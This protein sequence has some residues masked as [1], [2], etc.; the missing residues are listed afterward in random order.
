MKI[1]DWTDCDKI[2]F[3]AIWDDSGVHIG[4]IVVS[5]R[6]TGCWCGMDRFVGTKRSYKS[7]DYDDKE[8]AKLEAIEYF[9]EATK[10]GNHNLWGWTLFSEGD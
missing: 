8:V 5:V 10:T 4:S 6:S 2:S 9:Q 3:C 7:K 1:G